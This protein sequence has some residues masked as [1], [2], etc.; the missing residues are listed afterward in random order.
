MEFRLKLLILLLI[1]F[2]LGAA[3]SRNYTYSSG[4]TIDNAEVTSNEDAIFLYLQAGVDTYKAG[5][6]TGT[7]LSSSIAI[8]SSGNMT[9]SGTTNLTGTF[10]I[11]GTTVTSTATQ[12]NSL[13]GLTASA[14]EL[15]I[16]DGVTSTTAELNILDGVTATYAELNALDGITSSVAE[17]NILDGVTSTY[18]ELNTLDGITSTVTELNILDGVTSTASELNAL[19][20]ITATVTELNYTDGVTSNIQTQLDSKASSDGVVLPTGAVFFMLTGSCPAG[21]TDVTATYSNRFIRINAT[22]GTQAG[23]DTHTHTAGTLAG[24]SH[25]HTGPS[26]THGVGSFAGPSHTHTTSVHTHAAGTL[27]GPS[28]NHQWYNETTNGDPDQSYNSGGSAVTLA[29]G[30]SKAV[31]Q[32]HIIHTVSTGATLADAYT[33]LAGT[34]AITGS[35][36]SGGDAATGASGTGA[37]TGTSAAGGTGATGASGTGSVTGSTATGDNVPSF[38][39]CKMCQVN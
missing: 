8:T 19:D 36:A 6:I 33:S 13:S 30:A 37:V 32:A 38:L 24:P 10:Q 16:M 35:T 2:L 34:G 7:A 28:H 31:S 22:Q 29:A 12:L 9:F 26:H 23:A 20:G 21:T 27:A 5:S 4:T 14:A 1:P 18:L 39:T 3:P 15:N 17:L 25:T 11:N